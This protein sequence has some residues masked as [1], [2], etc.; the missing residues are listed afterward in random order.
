VA[1]RPR[2]TKSQARDRLREER[3]R[4]AAATKR[5]SNLMRLGLI[6][7][8]FVVVAAIGVA[9]V[10]SRSSSVSTAG[11]VPQGITDTKG[12]PTGTATKPVLDIWEDFQCPICGAFEAANRTQIEALATNGT[13]QVVY[14][15]WNFLDRNNVNNPSDTQQSSTR[16]AIAAGCAW[17]QGRFLQ[18]HDQIFEHQ[19]SD[20]AT[21]W[22]D[23]QL[24]GFAKAAGVSNTSTFD[25][26]LSSRKYQ[27][28]L[29]QVNAQA[30]KQQVTGTPTFFVN[31]QMVDLS[32]ATDPAGYGPIVI[33]AVNK[34][35]GT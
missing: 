6:G 21:G 30:D 16:A 27:D 5:R 22:T 3:A 31:G 24:E 26:C 33:A 1:T 35:A 15:T 9:V 8:V 25:Q 23:A 32:A 19:P 11:A 7:L 2:E 29:T 18:M 20:E 17:D 14:H 13:A 34:A 4:Q 10:V 28:F 12:Y